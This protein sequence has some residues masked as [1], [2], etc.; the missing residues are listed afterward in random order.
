MYLE[1]FITSHADFMRILFKAICVFEF[2]FYET[3]QE[4]AG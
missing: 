2:Y 1:W 4:R 3:K